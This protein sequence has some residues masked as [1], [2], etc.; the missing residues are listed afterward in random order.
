MSKTKIV[1]RELEDVMVSDDKKAF[2]RNIPILFALNILWRIHFF[3]SVMI[4]FFQ[5]WG[6]LTFSEI[7]ILESIFT[8]AIFL[9]EIPTG[10]IADKFGRKLSLNLAYVTNA[11]AVIVYVIYPRFYVFAIGEIIWAMAL[12]LNSGANEAIIYDTLLELGREKESKKIFSRMSSYGLIAMMI[13]TILGGIIASFGGLKITMTL[14]AIPLVLAFPLSFFLKEPT[15]HKLSKK[16][17]PWRIFQKGFKNMKENKGLRGLIVDMVLLSVIA[18]YAIWIWQR[19][20][21]ILNV[22]ISYFGL[23]HAGMMLIQVILLNLIIP[24]EKLFGSKKKVIIFTGAGMGAGYILFGISDNII[25]TIVGMLITV[26]LGFSRPVL[27]KNYMQ[28]HIQSEQRATTLSTVSMIR[29]FLLMILNPVI[30]ILVE[31]NMVAV[32]IGLGIVSVIWCFF[33]PVSEEYLHD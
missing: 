26:G 22:D 15:K 24:M 23:I 31:M 18:Y 28:K 16:E 4:P 14:S 11:L 30:G 7:M 1:E 17:S 13:G 12:A 20:L 27:M 32:L 6:G 10:T 3:G 21:M 29:M 2:Q 19:R 9:F 8:G 5:D 33:T 25:I